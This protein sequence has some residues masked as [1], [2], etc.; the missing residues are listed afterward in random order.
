MNDFR[1]LSAN[2]DE[3]NVLFDN[4]C[5]NMFLLCLIKNKV[6]VLRIISFIGS[7]I[8]SNCRSGEFLHVKLTF[9]IHN[10]LVYQDFFF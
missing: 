4:T 6:E 1:I 7:L 10:F 8:C 5:I 3:Y 2:I 9:K